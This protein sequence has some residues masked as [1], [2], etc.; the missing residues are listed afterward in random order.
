MAL[1]SSSMAKP[2]NGAAR[3]LVAL[4]LAATCALGLF[5]LMALMVDHGVKRANDDQSVLAFDMVMVEQDTDVQRR[6]RALPDPPKPPE[7]PEQ[8]KPVSQLRQSVATAQ[9]VIPNMSL[10]AGLDGVLIQAPTMGDFSVAETVGN[11]Q[12]MPLYRIE[13]TYPAKA[14][15]R[16]VEGYVVVSFTIDPSGRPVDLDIIEAKPRR[17]FEREAMRAIKRW[18]YQPKVVGGKAVSQPGQSVRLEFKL[19]R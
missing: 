18:K 13:P 4:P 15:K 17:M 2:G 3:M 8:L 14:L 19:N 1:S 7:M 6:K 12:A 11:Q 16:G 5:S 10:N 9:P